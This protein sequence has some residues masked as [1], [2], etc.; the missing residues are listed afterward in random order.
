M[1]QIPDSSAPPGPVYVHEVQYGLL[2]REA[3]PGDHVIAV[4]NDIVL[5]LTAIEL[6]R[7]LMSRGE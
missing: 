4:D 3:W 1:V 2:A 5:G 7:L 6:S